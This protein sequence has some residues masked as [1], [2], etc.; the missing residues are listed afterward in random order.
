MGLD[1]LIETIKKEQNLFKD[2]PVIR[3][4]LIGNDVR[5]I[6]QSA[7][8][9][10]KYANFIGLINEAMKDDFENDA[11]LLN[12][13]SDKKTFSEIID[14]TI[15]SLDRYQ[16]IQKAKIL[17]ILFVETF[18]NN[19]FSFD[20]YNI[21][22]FSIEFIHPSIGVKCLK[23]FYDY[24]K[25]MSKEEDKEKKDA[26]WMKNSSLDYS[27]LANTGLLILPN[28]GMYAGNYGGAFINKLGYRFYELVVSKV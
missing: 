4:L 12:I 6:I 10:K 26:I 11:K 8:F 14:Q 1:Q 21:L 16:T 15:I 27:P 28:G 13:F 17:S 7:F 3:W 18:K 25:E 20:D 5:T 22:I 9:I 24:K 2:I 23:S 19:N